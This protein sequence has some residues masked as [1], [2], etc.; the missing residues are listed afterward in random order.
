M[1]SVSP[2]TA[3]AKTTDHKNDNTVGGSLSSRGELSN[4]LLF[5]SGTTHDL[6]M[7]KASAK[8]NGVKA[9][10]RSPPREAIGK[11]SRIKK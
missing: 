9:K 11:D 4:R 2:C 10:N 1:N 5:H 8:T 7:K 3:V 6:I